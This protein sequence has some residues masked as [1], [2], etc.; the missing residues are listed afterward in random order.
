MYL[1][2]IGILFSGY[3]IDQ[4]F[5]MDLFS[6]VTYDAL[7][8]LANK[9]TVD[10]DLTV[11]LIFGDFI[12]GVKVLFGIITGDTI[13]GALTTLPFMNEVWLLLS[14]LVFTLS[15]ALLWVYVVAGRSV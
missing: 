12:A 6:S 9:N 5:G 15:S 3:Y 2:S 7:D 8:E 4:V 10:E 14:R 13:S 1:F 11:D